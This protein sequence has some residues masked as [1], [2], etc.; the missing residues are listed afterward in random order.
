MIQ[1]NAYRTPIT[2]TVLMIAQ[3]EV[4]NLRVVLLHS[5]TV[6]MADAWTMPNDVM[7]IMTVGTTVMKRIV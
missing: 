2:A 7:V 3:T 6:Q 1:V 5:L 4:T